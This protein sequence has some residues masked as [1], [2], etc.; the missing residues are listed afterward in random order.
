MPDRSGPQG[1]ESEARELV[2]RLGG[3]WTP[4]GGLCLCP[5]HADR[6][7]SLSVRVGRTSLLLHCF[8]GC[9]A[10]DILRA[11]RAAGHP[12]GQ[13]I[14]NEQPG[15]SPS[16]EREQASRASRAALR[17]WG[18]SRPIGGTPAADYLGDRGVHVA[19]AELRYNPRTPHGPRPLTR[20][21]PALVAAV[22]D[23]SGLVA[24]HRSFLDVR[25]R[26]L[27]PMEEPRC[28][29]GRFG[30]GAVRLGGIAARLGF[31]EGI[32]T[33][34][35]AS[36][37]FGIPCWATLGTERFGLVALPGAVEQLVL[38][39]DNDSGGRRAEA[40]ARAAF[41][42]IPI[43]VERPKRPGADWNDVLRARL[44]GRT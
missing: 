29:L 25:R 5:A 13:G 37:L 42:H 6:A 41:A 32:E 26:R 38:F 10:A 34:L 12:L 43:D 31:A 36:I 30:R 39:T 2:E 23:E 35:S 40:L 18:S 3:R 7:P 33:A 15:I 24:V 28:G 20:F 9:A 14:G 4:G 1:L 44:R 11:M 16:A 8:A 21:R 27:A 17:L 19:S 22:R